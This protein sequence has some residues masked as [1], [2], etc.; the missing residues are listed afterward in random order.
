MWNWYFQTVSSREA[1]GQEPDERVLGCLATLWGGTAKLPSKF[2][3]HYPGKEKK[4]LPLFYRVLGTLQMG[5]CLDQPCQGPL[6][7]VL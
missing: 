5:C 2:S 4:C 6:G 7:T 3:L 1:S